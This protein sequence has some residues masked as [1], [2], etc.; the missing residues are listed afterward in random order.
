MFL[1]PKNN[2]LID[3]N[4]DGKG[5]ELYWNEETK[6]STEK[7]AQK[8][9]FDFSDPYLCLAPG[10]GFYTKRWP[11]EN[12]EQL[13][14]LVRKEF[15]YQVVL[16]GGEEDIEL[17]R[18]LGKE[19][20]VYDFT[21]KLTLLE[22]GVV[23]SQGK[24]LV[25]NDTGLMHMATAVDTPVLAIFGSTVRE[26]GFFPFRGK[27]LVLENAE[28]SCRPCTHIGRKKCPKLHFECMLKISTEDVFE[29]LKLFVP[30]CGPE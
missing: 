30:D 12:F 26:F 27:S 14:G 23:L 17:G 3:I 13:I 21:G 7:K 24:G 8:I 28:L 2:K 10:A 16:L 25:S 22:T 4:D 18:F 6:I 5:L 11:A 9:G 15:N 1:M 19:D 29:N 20:S